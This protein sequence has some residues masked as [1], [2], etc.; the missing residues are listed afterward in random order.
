MTRVDDPISTAIA[1]APAQNDDTL[2]GDSWLL[3]F[4]T[5][6]TGTKRDDAIV[7]ASLVLRNPDT[8]FEGDTVAEWLINPHHRMN[9][10]AS[11]VNGFTDTF[12]EQNGEE[13]TQAL[14][15]I[16]TAITMAQDKGI[17]LLAY[18]A[19]FDVRMLSGDLGRWNLQGLPER[20]LVADPLVIDREISHR[21]GKRNLAHTT[22]YYGV[23]PHG[24]FHDATADTI[25]A[26]DLIQPMSRL[27]PQVGALR[28]GELMDWQRQAHERWLVSFNQWLV[29]RGRRSINDTWL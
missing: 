23:D 1:A 27:Y 29:S 4:D 9:P 11:K 13:P 14:A 3:G 8:G 21:N 6:T 17:P 20:L 18:N 16:A 26:V 15:N 2:L 7:S 5:E 12:L 28:L 10:A 19:P 22:E 25:A 24:D